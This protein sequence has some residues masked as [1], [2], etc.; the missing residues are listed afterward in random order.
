MSAPKPVC[1]IEELGPAE[2]IPHLMQRHRSQYWDLK[3][4]LGDNTLSLRVSE[5][6]VDRDL[7]AAYLYRND[8]KPF[9]LECHPRRGLIVNCET[10][11]DK[12][13]DLHTHLK[14]LFQDS[15]VWEWL[16]QRIGQKVYKVYT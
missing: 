12:G 14:K 11:P 7:V 1:E 4:I 13:E 5:K 15:K 6:H 10:M 3:V 8:P 9:I 2:S 16:N